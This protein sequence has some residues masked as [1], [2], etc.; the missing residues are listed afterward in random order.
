VLHIRASDL[1]DLEGLRGRI[2]EMLAVLTT[3]AAG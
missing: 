1:K 2:V 3:H